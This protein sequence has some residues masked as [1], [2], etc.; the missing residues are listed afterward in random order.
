MGKFL[1]PLELR[2]TEQE[3]HGRPIFRLT[4]QFRYLVGDYTVTV[5][6]GFLTDLASVPRPFWLW[7]QPWTGLKAAIP[8][9]YLCQTGE[10][11]RIVADAIYRQALRDCGVGPIRRWLMWL[12]VRIGAGRQ[13]FRR[14]A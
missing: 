8:H 10:Q 11:P 14:Q 13:H 4:R 3:S 6:E 5:P 12:A 2:V 1:D 9:D 7:I